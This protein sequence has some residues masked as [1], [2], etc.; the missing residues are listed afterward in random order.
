MTVIENKHEKG[1]LEFFGDAETV[2]E[3]KKLS[4]PAQMID[5]MWKVPNL[6]NFLKDNSEPNFGKSDGDTRRFREMGNKLF[7]VGKDKEAIKMFNK[8]ITKAPTNESGKGKDLSLA[9]A[10]RSAALYKLGYLQPALDDIEFAFESGYPKDLKYKLFE[11][12]IRI[13]VDM[14]EKEKAFDTRS[15]FILALKDS[16][17][18]EVKRCKTE[19]EIQAMLDD[20]DIGTTKEIKVDKKLEY[21]MSQ[22]ALGDSHAFLPCLSSNVDIEYDPTRGRFAVANKDIKAGSVI[23]VESAV[24]SV[25]KEDQVESYCDLCFKNINLRLIPCK[26]CCYVAYCSKQCLKD[27]FESYHKYECGNTDM[28]S[29][30]LEN[31][32]KDGKK[33]IG[34]TKDF[35][36]LCYRAIAKKPLSWYKENKESLSAEFP[37]WGDESFDKSTQHALLNLVSHHDR[38]KP[39]R[40]W[41]FLISAICQ[42]KAYQMSGYF[43]CKKLKTPAALTEDEVYIGGLLVHLFELMQFNTHGVTESLDREPIKK[44]AEV[45]EFDNRIR[46]VG[47]GLYPTLCLFN[48]SC[49]NNTYKYYAGSNLV[50][51]ASKN[52]YEGEEVTEGYFPTAQ[53]IPRPQR[54][55]WLAEH[56]WFECQCHACIEDL[57]TL[58]NISKQYQNFCCQKKNCK[59]VVPETTNCPACGDTIDVDANKVNIEKVKQSLETL[60]SKMTTQENS[61]PEDTF[62]QITDT[63]MRLQELVR[64]PY[65]LLY[66]TEQLFWKALRLSHGNYAH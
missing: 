60:K 41:S 46:L 38:I 34:S 20:L 40:L 47:N 36:K 50:V 64:H 33:D 31:I 15:D 63:W 22:H 23:L 27:A 54:R 26:S 25:C 24:A 51:I 11:R 10:N 7:K 6:Q 1:L 42:L 18:D 29:K 39:G 44:N 8:A 3:F 4:N 45:A 13:L 62:H 66:T 65:K 32:Q 61:N 2:K 57:P 55:A 59:G 43:G 58:E 17:L 21:K 35:S 16:T 48:H 14:Q 28:F 49:D 12:K 19:N 56:Y 5:F 37:K 52:I 30:V 53:M 9:V